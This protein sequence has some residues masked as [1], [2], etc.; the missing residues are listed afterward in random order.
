MRVKGAAWVN[1]SAQPRGC[2][3]VP[4][5]FTQPRG[6]SGVVP[7]GVWGVSQGGLWY[8]SGESQTEGASGGGAPGVSLA[9]RSR[10]S[11][12]RSAGGSLEEPQGENGGV[13]V[14]GAEGG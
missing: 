5:D 7:G 12:G 4:G 3:S 8:L 14:G 1:G 2:R 9:G 6:L 13:G 11:H 10:G